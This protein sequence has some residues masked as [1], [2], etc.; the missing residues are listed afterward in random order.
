MKYLHHFHPELIIFRVIC[1]RHFYSNSKCHHIIPSGY[2]IIIS[3]LVPFQYSN[4]LGLFSLLF[5]FSPCLFFRLFVLRFLIFLLL[6]I[7]TFSFF[8]TFGSI[9]S[10][11]IYIYEIKIDLR[12]PIFLLEILKPLHNYLKGE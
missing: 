4:L 11:S 5:P 12:I 8:L 1:R 3:Q 7:L 6:S 10:I 9:W 2:P